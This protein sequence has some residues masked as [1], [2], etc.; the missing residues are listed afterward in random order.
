MKS[1]AE[2]RKELGIEQDAK[3]QRMY[4][5]HFADGFTK[6]YRSLA[7]AYSYMNRCK[8]EGRH[9]QLLMDVEYD[10]TDCNGECVTDVKLKKITEF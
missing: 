4:Y 10:Y 8:A 6:M 5:V 7:Y 9:G 3:H 1:A 2:I